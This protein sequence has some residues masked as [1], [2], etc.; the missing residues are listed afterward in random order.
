VAGGALGLAT[1]ADAATYMGQQQN[2]T[3]AV[4]GMNLLIIFAVVHVASLASALLPA[5]RASRV[6]PAEALRYE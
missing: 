4:P 3:L 1:A 5:R 6:Y 2:V